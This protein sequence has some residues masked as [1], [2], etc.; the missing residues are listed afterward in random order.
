M[1]EY[2]IRCIGLADGRPCG[3]EGLL[4]RDFDAEFRNGLGKADW[5][6]T[7]AHALRFPSSAEAFAFWK[8]QSRTRPLRPD[9]KANRPLTAFTVDLEKAPPP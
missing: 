3:T 5:T 2:V 8:T 4:L 7:P 1:T 6:S 9:G